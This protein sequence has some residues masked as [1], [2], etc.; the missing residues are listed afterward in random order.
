MNKQTK[1]NDAKRLKLLRKVCKIILEINSLPDSSNSI[2]YLHL[3]LRKGETFKIIPK[4]FLNE[5]DEKSNN[6]KS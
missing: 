3:H 2:S 4:D 5:T 6:S 1:K